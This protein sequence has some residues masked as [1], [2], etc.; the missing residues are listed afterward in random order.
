MSTDD[1]AVLKDV[2]RNVM[3]LVSERRKSLGKGPALEV[4]RQ[5]VGIIMQQ[6]E[7]EPFKTA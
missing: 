7:L 5:Q 6:H 2:G 4:S 3:Y 1:G